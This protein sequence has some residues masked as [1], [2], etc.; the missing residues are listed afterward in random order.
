[1]Q[2]RIHIIEIINGFFRPPILAPCQG[3]YYVPAIIADYNILGK[4]NI[5][6]HICYIICLLQSVISIQPSWPSQKWTTV[7]ASKPERT[8]L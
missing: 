3:F 2:G 8:L 6:S 5:G 7:P 1:M 4:T